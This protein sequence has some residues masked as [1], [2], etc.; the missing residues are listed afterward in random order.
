MIGMTTLFAMLANSF[1]AASGA[2]QVYG[3]G[4]MGRAR[5]SVR[6]GPHEIGDLFKNLSPEENCTRR[7]N[8]DA[9]RERRADKLARET[10]FAFGQNLAH[11]S[12]R[13]RSAGNLP[14]RLNP[15]YVAK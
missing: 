3:G 7:L 8:A 4:G 11:W 2:T 15:F 10:N 12:V 6:R 13:D 5:N 14:K 1:A 9:K